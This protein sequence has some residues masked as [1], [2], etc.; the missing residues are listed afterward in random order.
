MLK[1]FPAAPATAT[2]ESPVRKLG[3][4]ACGGPLNIRPWTGDAAG[5]FWGGV[6]L[7]YIEMFGKNDIIFLTGNGRSKEA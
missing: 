5:T 6:N 7:P 1:T 3:S 4:P 2:P